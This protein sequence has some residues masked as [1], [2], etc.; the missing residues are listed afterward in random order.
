M[1]GGYFILPHPVFLCITLTMSSV[2]NCY[3]NSMQGSLR[4]YQHD[5]YMSSAICTEILFIVLSCHLPLC[6]GNYTAQLAY[7]LR[8]PKYVK[9]YNSEWNPS[10]ES[11]IFDK[12]V[13]ESTIWYAFCSSSLD[14][15]Y[16][17]TLESQQNVTICNFIN[18][19]ELHYYSHKNITLQHYILDNY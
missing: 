7:F 8:F 2:I 17:T 4:L 16:F 12:F 11:Q 19:T 10:Q 18:D 14:C 15:Q 6:C 9:L 5:K 3:L 1:L 13:N